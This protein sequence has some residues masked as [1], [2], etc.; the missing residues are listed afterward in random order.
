MVGSSQRLA[1]A[2]ISGLGA[3]CCVAAIRVAKPFLGAAITV[4]A[5]AKQ[6]PPKLS[7]HSP[8]GPRSAKL[9]TIRFAEYTK[10]AIILCERTIAGMVRT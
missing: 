10:S 4:A 9:I 3:A 5:R 7:V 2:V 8:L 6:E 1:A